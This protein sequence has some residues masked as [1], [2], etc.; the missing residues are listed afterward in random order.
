MKRVRTVCALS[1]ALLLPVLAR[2]EDPPPSGP[3]QIFQRQADHQDATDR[4]RNEAPEGH[5]DGHAADSQAHRVL[6]EPEMASAVP[7][8]DLAKGTI[9]IDVAGP[10]GKP[11]AGAKIVL[12]VMAS[13]GGRS[14][15]Q[16]TTDAEGSF[17]FTDLPVG[18][19]QA[20]RVNVLSAGAKF[21]STPFRL[22]DAEGYRVR[23]P[24]LGTTQSDRLVFQLIGQTVVELRDDRLHITQQARL[25]NAGDEVFVLPENGLVVDLPEGFTAFQW[26][27][28]MTDQRGEQVLGTGFRLRGSLPP[29]NVTLGW[30]YDVPRSG[31]SAKVPVK[32]P[33]R[34]YTYRVI[35]EAP[36]GLSLRVSEFPEPERVKDE[37]RTLLFTQVQRQPTDAPL[38]SLTIKLDGIPG[39]GPGRYVAVA[40]FALMVAAGLVQ[41]SRRASDTEDRRAALADRKKA[42]LDAAKQA[43]AEHARGDTGPEF[44]AARLADLTTELALVL[45]D[46]E[47]L[48]APPTRA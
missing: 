20:Y 39:P 9:Q 31:A 13:M 45:R 24:V 6:R 27:D 5:A 10:D 44:H 4:A 41:A 28:Q 38:N 40:L 8:S 30:T 15:Q 47:G 18:S 25:A 48:G 22:P 29:G 16:A 3:A 46:E 43:D 34:T 36:D 1:A 23:I 42:L 14:E 35:S 32:L 17:R 19:A 11:L 21:S 2:A 12:G 33:F 26:Q 7:A 37:G